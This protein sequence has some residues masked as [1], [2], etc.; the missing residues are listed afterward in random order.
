MN[1]TLTLA[2][3]IIALSSFI[4]AW[5]LKKLARKASPYL[6]FA[7]A[8]IFIG[9]LILGFAIYDF[10]TAEGEFAGILGEVALLIGEPIVLTLLFI[11]FIAWYIRKAHEADVK[12]NV[13]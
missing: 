10:K 1:S 3:I 4:I 6:L 13:K 9:L 5:I 2:I 7:V 8:D 11:D 12:R